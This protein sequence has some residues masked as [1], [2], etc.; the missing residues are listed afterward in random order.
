MIEYF[1]EQIDKATLLT[2]EMIDKRN[3]KV[4][5]YGNELIVGDKELFF[6]V[7]TTDGTKVSL[8][9]KKIIERAFPHFE[10]EYEYVRDAAGM[11][12]V[13][14]LKDNA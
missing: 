7:E 12:S 2:Q 9:I 10:N 13:F 4:D 8:E 3:T 11:L 6:M 5:G 1:Q 14:K